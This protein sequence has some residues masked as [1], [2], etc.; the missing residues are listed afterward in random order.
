MNVQQK[1]RSRNTLFRKEKKRN[2]KKVKGLRSEIA[3][4]WGV[5]DYVGLSSPLHLETLTILIS[6]LV[7]SFF[8]S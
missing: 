2:E 8:F 1:K 6:M 7:L 3:P 4:S 5:F